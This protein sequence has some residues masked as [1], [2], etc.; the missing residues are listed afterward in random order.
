MLHL[1][2]KGISFLLA[3]DAFVQQILTLLI[4][5]TQCIVKKA[6]LLKGIR[7]DDLISHD[8]MIDASQTLSNLFCLF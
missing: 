7:G 1:L 6:L 5:Y 3:V 8:C 4:H 2:D